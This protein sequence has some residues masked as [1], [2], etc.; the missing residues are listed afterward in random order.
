VMAIALACLSSRAADAPHVTVLLVS[1]PAS[2]RDLPLDALRNC[3]SRS[4]VRAEK[5]SCGAGEVCE[6]VRLVETELTDTWGPYKII[7]EHP[8]GDRT[9]RQKFNGAKSRPDLYF[10]AVMDRLREAV[11][12]HLRADHGVEPNA[13]SDSDLCK[14]CG[15]S[16]PLTDIVPVRKANR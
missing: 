9:Y 5:G 11:T 12:C 1:F 13:E 7:F 2:F 14:Q 3:C 8:A 4:N 10:H 16:K 6:T 15:E